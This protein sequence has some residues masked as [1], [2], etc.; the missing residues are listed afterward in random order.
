MTISSGDHWSQRP[1]QGHGVMRPRSSLN[2]AER[3]QYSVITV[4]CPIRRAEMNGIC[5]SIFSIFHS[6]VVHRVI[7]SGCTSSDLKTFDI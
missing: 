3:G 7:A 1:G 5:Q 2:I 4:P 6:S